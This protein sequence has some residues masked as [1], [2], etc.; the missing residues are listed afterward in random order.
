MEN[1][2]MLA[3]YATASRYNNLQTYRRDFNAGAGFTGLSSPAR[4][5]LSKSSA[6]EIKVV[7]V[8]VV[9]LVEAAPER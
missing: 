8:G 2:R 6:I 1:E 3:D 7:D 5:A 9:K 4:F